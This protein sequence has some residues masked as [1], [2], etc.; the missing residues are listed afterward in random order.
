MTVFNELARD[1]KSDTNKAVGLGIS[2]TELQ[3]GTITVTG[4]K[5][6]NFK[7]EVKDYMVLDYL[8]LEDEYS[9]ETAGEHSH[10]HIIKVPERLKKL[11]IGDRVLIAQ[12][13]NEYIV[14]GRLI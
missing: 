9:T 1:I 2:N 7:N 13:G 6:D 11:K 4:L 10:N 5:L 12:S 3:F 14:I 8:K